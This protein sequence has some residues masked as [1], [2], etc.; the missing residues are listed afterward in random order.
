M[1]LEDMIYRR[2]KVYRL[3]VKNGA[4][5]ECPR[6]APAH[7]TLVLSDERGMKEMPTHPMVEKTKKVMEEVVEGRVGVNTTKV[8]YQ[9][10]LGDLI[11]LGDVV[12][13]ITT[14]TSPII[15]GG[16]QKDVKE[17]LLKWQNKIVEKVPELRRYISTTVIDAVELWLG[18]LIVKVPTVDTKLE[19]IVKSIG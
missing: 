13:Y 10:Y 3:C 1:M 11:E 14:F 18:V 5:F 17:T 8:V 12:G 19:E 7:L 4:V 16:N 6:N 15:L 2:N 9:L